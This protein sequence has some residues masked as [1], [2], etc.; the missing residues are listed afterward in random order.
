M[1]QKSEVTSIFKTF[2]KWVENQC[3][4]KIKVIRSDNGTQYTFDKFKEFCIDVG[5]EHQFTTVYTPQQNGVSER[6]NITIMEMARCLLFEKK[7]P[8]KFWAKVVNTATY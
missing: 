6:K 8:N 2:K 7:L 5:I 3:D 4:I 1:R